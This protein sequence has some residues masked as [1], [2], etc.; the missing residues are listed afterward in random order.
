MPKNNWLI[1]YLLFACTHALAQSPF[2]RNLE[3]KVVNKG[4][5]IADVHVM[6]TSRNRATISEESGKFTIGVNL[7]DTLLF[8]AVQFK[9][10]TL[11]ISGAMLESIR[12]EV[13]L[14]EFVNELD[15]VILRPYDLTGD[16]TRDMKQMK[17]D[18]VVTAST[19]GLPNAYVKPLTQAERLKHEATTGG[20]LVPLNPILNAI[21]GRTKYLKKRIATENKYA[22]T[23]RVRAFYPDSLFVKELSIPESKIDD[24]MYYCEVD[25]AF[26][27]V[28]DTHDRLKIW[29]YLKKKSTLYR[30]DNELD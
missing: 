24:F 10:K 6:N 4:E 27:T 28:V 29:E 23:D 30:R 2:T 7:G 14:E 5:G 11:V 1:L 17:T 25:F 19:L 22:R 26:S 13:P 12:I 21:S 18:G 9:R 15:E 20:G 3:G 16:L 8:S